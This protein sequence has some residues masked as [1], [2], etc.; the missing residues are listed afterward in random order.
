MAMA[1]RAKQRKLEDPVEIAHP[2]RS[3]A[4][5]NGAKQFAVYAMGECQI[6]AGIEP[7]GHHGEMRW[8]MSISHPRRYPSWDE[9]AHARYAV[10]PDEANMMMSLPSREDYVNVHQ[11]C[12][13]LFEIVEA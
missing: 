6:F 7:C 1:R 11:H 12:F 8:H 4:H 3:V 10:V 2:M 9:I 13:H 5:Q